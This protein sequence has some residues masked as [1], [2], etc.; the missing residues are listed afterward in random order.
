ML[1]ADVCILYGHGQSK[2]T[3]C[4]ASLIDLGKCEVPEN[5]L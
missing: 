3:Q 1:P 2:I 4:V 5:V